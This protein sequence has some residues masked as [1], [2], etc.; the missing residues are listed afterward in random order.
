MFIEEAFQVGYALIMQRYRFFTYE[1]KRN[2]TY[3]NFYT[4]L[5]ELDSAANL[6]NLE[7]ND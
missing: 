5:Q 4:K 6:E 3:T 1:R 2:Q 7:L